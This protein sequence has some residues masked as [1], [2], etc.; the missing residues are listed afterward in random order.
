MCLDTITK[1]GLNKSGYGWKVF[2]VR[3]GKLYGDNY[4]TEKPKRL[5]RWLKARRVKIET[6]QHFSYSEY[7]SGFHI[8]I[9]RNDAELWQY[10]MRGDNS[11]TKRVK[12]RKAHTI[13]MQSG[14]YLLD[15][16][17]IVADEMLI[18]PSKKH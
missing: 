8:F 9:E 5:N 18:C 4:F 2:M 6:Y 17:T 1:T 10:G 7:F 16:G 14:S 15:G 11:V 3:N 12:Y 13:G